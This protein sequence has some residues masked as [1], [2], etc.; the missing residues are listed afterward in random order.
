MSVVGL[1]LL[2]FLKNGDFP[3]LRQFAL[4][5]VAFM[6]ATGSTLALHFVFGPYI[7]YLYEI[8]VR[9]CNAAADA[10]ADG[11]EGEEKKEKAGQEFLLQ[12]TTRS[13]F[14][15]KKEHV[16]HPLTDVT[17]YAGMRP[18]ANF[19]IKG[20]TTL[21]AH[22]YLLDDDTRVKLLH[23]TAEEEEDET[24]TKPKEQNEGKLSK[25]KKQD[26]DDDD[27]LF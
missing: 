13:I 12:A 18:F 4:G 9:Q 24:T 11:E 7:H 10:S 5:G 15:W 1:P 6:G 17:H 3:T 27:G 8:P 23:P 19:V 16:F 20:D 26:D 25:K 14:G 22:P 21:Y 2:I